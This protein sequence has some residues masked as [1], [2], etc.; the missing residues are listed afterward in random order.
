MERV[1]TGGYGLLLTEVPTWNLVQ[2]LRLQRDDAAA[3]VAEVRA[4]LH[5]RGRS[6]AAWHVGPSS[7][8]DLL[9]WLLEMG[10]TPYDEPPLEAHSS[11]MAL[12]HAPALDA[13]PDV[14]V[15]RA[16]TLE[17]LAAAETIAAQAFALRA[18]DRRAIEVN[19]KTRLRLQQQ[20]RAWVWQYIASIDGVPVGTARARFLKAGVNLNG[21]AV[22]PRARR[23]GVYL[24]LVAA[25]WREAIAQGTPALT[26]QAGAMSRPILEKLGFVTVAEITVLHDRLP[27]GQ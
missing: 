4:T 22:L 23:R 7:P 18:E 6:Q 15:E 2:R 16:D 27:T 10:M 3:A 9:P 13:I 24:A 12:V 1:L 5:G 19:L 25:R 11:C 8:A 20:N 17:A 14:V 26:V 21:A